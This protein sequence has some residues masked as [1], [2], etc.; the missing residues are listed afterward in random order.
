MHQGRHLLPRRSRN[1]PYGS[2]VRNRR[3]RRRGLQSASIF[4]PGCPEAR[5]YSETAP[6]GGF[7]LTRIPRRRA[8]A[9][10]GPRWPFGAVGRG[11][12][13][14]VASVPSIRDWSQESAPPGS[15][16]AG[17]RSSHGRRGQYGASETR[18]LDGPGSAGRF[19]GNAGPAGEEKIGRAFLEPCPGSGCGS[20]SGYGLQE[21]LCQPSSACIR[22]SDGYRIH[23]SVRRRCLKPPS[24]PHVHL[25]DG[26]RPL[27]RPA[28]L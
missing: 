27:G 24:P 7:P 6:R 3:L 25:P 23:H 5:L 4:P 18:R 2:L 14:G 8:L 11:E 20:S 9:S 16:G 1:Q 21:R 17:A 10:P 28:V 13:Y 26:P 19:S 15:R 22:I 12:P